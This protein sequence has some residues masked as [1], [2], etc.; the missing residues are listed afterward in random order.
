MTGKVST[1]F[2]TGQAEE[3]G[4]EILL[5]H[6]WELPRNLKGDPLRL[7]QV[8][9][10]LVG[11]AI[12]FTEQ[13]EI[14]IR[15]DEISRTEQHVMMKFEVQ[16]SGIGIS[17]AEARRLFKP[18]GQADSSTTRRY[19]GSGLGLVISKQLVEMM[20]GEIWVESN[21]ENGSC[22]AFTC[23]FELD[24][25]TENS[26][27]QI[28]SLQGTR[29]LIVDDSEASR[30]VL[31]S[32][33][34]NFGMYS[35]TVESGE[36]AITEL[37]RAADAG[38]PGY[39]LLLL[40]WHM[41]GIDG[42]ECAHQI[43]MM[44]HNEPMPALVMVTA[45][46][47]ED[48][49]QN[50]QSDH[51]D[52]FLLKPVS[53]SL[54]LSAILNALNLESTEVRRHPQPESRHEQS[55]AGIL[56]ARILVVE[57]NPTNQQ[58]ATEMLEGLGANVTVSDNGQQALQRVDEEQFD[59]V[60]MDIQ[61]PVMDGIES[62]KQIRL[63]EQGQGLPIV[64]MTANAMQEDYERS[65]A[66]GMDDHLNKPIQ[67]EQLFST[68]SHWIAPGRHLQQMPVQQINAPCIEGLDTEGGLARLNG[69]M[70]LY[71][72]L[73]RQFSNEQSDV[74]YQ[75]R[76]LLGQERTDAAADQIH[77]LAGLCGNLGADKLFQLARELEVQLRKAPEKNLSSSLQEIEA[78]LLKLIHSISSY[79]DSL[80]QASAL[81]AASL[82]SGEFSSSKFSEVCEQLR[83][84]LEE[85]DSGSTQLVSEL[86]KLLA[87]ESG[88]HFK[89]LQNAVDDYE[90]DEALLALDVLEAERQ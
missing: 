7:G 46:N 40:D 41:P 86:E 82:S 19:G 77:T 59:L 10:N 27:G 33:V 13:G 62:T 29:V 3:K 23:Q 73:L 83:P 90:F 50:A 78:E 84:M 72:K 31:S 67:P 61:M 18:F 79:L 21:K 35:Y 68:L 1:L 53:P 30:D 88:E 15:V 36:A 71:H 60:L 75:I 11:N 64:A 4:L 76:R 45:H 69:N 74:L 9:T 39:N 42:M 38:E 89:Q 2:R 44:S 20:G 16:D 57:D 24:E 12:K 80:E 48:I 81:S 28:Q 49:L 52:G 58:I 26:E 54:L 47:R 6:P 32:I 14:S 51:L 37:Q 70:D 66:A 8:L 34:C 17:D 65:I 5:F 55:L 25:E 87:G 85:G 22:F 63:L 43:K 56:G